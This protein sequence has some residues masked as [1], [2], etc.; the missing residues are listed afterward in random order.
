[1]MLDRHEAHDE[2]NSKG[3]EPAREA[4]PSPDR[5]LADREVPLPGTAAADASAS[6]INQWLDGE[7]PE[8][9][10]RRADAKAVEFWARVDLN[11]D[12]MRRMKTPAHV[13]AAIMAAIPVREPEAM[14]AMPKT[15][16]AESRIDP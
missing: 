6:V 1:M 16:N 7:A 14:K 13:A 12:R 10:A 11:T 4:A 2:L 9:E 15:T 5:P 8:A 3:R